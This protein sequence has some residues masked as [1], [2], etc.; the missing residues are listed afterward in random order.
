M[1]LVKRWSGTMKSGGLLLGMSILLWVA[2]NSGVAQ[3][4]VLTQHND[5]ERTGA[6]LHETV[7]TH[8]NVN[9][10]QFGMLFKRVVDDQVYGQPLYVSHVKVGGGFH[11][12]VYVTTVN[13]SVYAFDANEASASRPL[14]HVNFGMPANLH[15][16][17]FGCLDI[18]GNMGIVG[19]PVIDQQSGTLYVVALTRA[20]SGFIQR[21]HALDI[22]TG[23]DMPESP[24]T[25]TAHDFDPLME[26]QRPA[27][28]LS[29]GTVYVG[30]ASHCDKEPYHGFLMGYD[31]K[32]LR[33]TAVLNTSPTGS[34]ASIWQSGQAPAVDA[35]GNIYVV[36]GN[37]SWDGKVNFSESFLKLNPELKVLDWFTP[38][39]HFDLD[40]KDLDINSSGAT[41]IPGTKL[42]LGGGKEGVLYVLD[43]QHLGHLGDENALQ[44]FQASGS[45]LHSFVYWKSD[46][47][48][49]LL[50]VWGQRDR[51]RVYGLKG[52]RLSETPVM[53]RPEVNEGHPG[54][55]LSL[56]A[57]GGKEG[58]LWAAIHATGDS[59]HE[60]RPGILHAYDAD[61]IEHELWNSLE[62][63]GRDDCSNYSKMAPPTIANGKV[64]LASFGTENV[65]TGQFCVYGLLPDGPVPSTPEGLRADVQDGVV[66]L[67]WVAV[68]GARTYNVKSQDGSNGTPRLLASGLV[69]T[70]FAGITPY[71]GTSEYVVTAV[72]SNGESIA[73]KPVIVDLQRAAAV[74]RMHPGMH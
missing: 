11:D 4:S 5:R 36:T 61:N 62:D 34:E 32:S 16:A 41:L 21:L 52:D 15:D 46:K 3:V 18:N 44:H 2:G 19:T 51:A 7:L 13:N 9:V 10:K 59:W 23:A 58:I 39:N 37:G 40:A 6:N 35:E 28:L 29:R 14:W 38:T 55:M 43:Q 1:R 57:N 48:G 68:P 30:Y 56:S 67:S 24:V 26:N 50:Y 60:S 25:I 27:L 20:G 49:S 33:Q 65:G 53:M 17:N 74:E 47:K 31:A 66:S 71:A 54:A 42:V 70:A 69:S 73:S 12:V 8:E 63:P 72:N 45:H 64:Y 22:A